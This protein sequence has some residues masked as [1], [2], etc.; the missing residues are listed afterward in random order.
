MKKLML[1]FTSLLF[2]LISCEGDSIPQVQLKTI[3]YEGEKYKIKKNFVEDFNGLETDD[4]KYLAST[5]SQLLCEGEDMYINPA[6]IFET[7]KT[8]GKKGYKPLRYI[9]KFIRSKK[10]ETKDGIELTNSEEF[11]YPYHNTDGESPFTEYGIGW[12]EDNGYFCIG[13]IVVVWGK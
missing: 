12:G 2:L 8:Y 6:W 13:A 5:Y 11:Y 4:L 9:V 1:L 3:D 7:I 10:K